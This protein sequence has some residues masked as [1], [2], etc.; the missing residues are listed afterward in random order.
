MQNGLGGLNVPSLG[1]DKLI[2]R[3]S[4]LRS[5]HM[6][7]NCVRRLKSPETFAL[8]LFMWIGPSVIACTTIHS[9]SALRPPG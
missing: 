7:I 6:H 2:S 8:D 9:S 5:H 4:M 3:H 1:N